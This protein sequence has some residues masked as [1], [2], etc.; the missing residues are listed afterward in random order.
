MVSTALICLALLAVGQSGLP[1]CCTEHACAKLSQ[2]LKAGAQE[3]GRRGRD[4]HSRPF[5]SCKSVAY[6]YSGGSCSSARTLQTAVTMQCMTKGG[7]ESWAKSSAGVGVPPQ[8]YAGTSSTSTSASTWRLPRS[9]S[10]PRP[11]PRRHAQPEDSI[12]YA[13]TAPGCSGPSLTRSSLEMTTPETLRSTNGESLTTSSPDISS[14]QRTF[15]GWNWAGTTPASSQMRNED[16]A[17]ST[18]G[19]SSSSGENGG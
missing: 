17:D 2:L 11:R 8:D 19:S 7:T 10:G 5:T 3:Q 15:S 1:S 18:P 12:F 14:E 16:C 4:G 9:Q 6:S 13:V